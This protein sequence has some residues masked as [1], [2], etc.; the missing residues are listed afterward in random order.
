MGTIRPGRTILALASAALLAAAL[1][2]P[3]AAGVAHRSASPPTPTGTGPA[4]ACA[5]GAKACPIRIVFRPGAYSGQASSAL[6][7]QSSEKWF[8][9]RARAGQTLVV[10]IVGAGATG[11]TIYFPGGG[12][13][14]GPGGRIFDGEVPKTGVYRIRVSESLMAEG[15]SGRVTVVVMVY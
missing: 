2:T 8:T 4:A 15:W 12:Q 3:A 10:V 5:R 9:V 13:D 11:G 7:D 1:S 14:G 6:A